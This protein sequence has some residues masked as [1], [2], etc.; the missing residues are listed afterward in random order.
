MDG[1]DNFINYCDKMMIATEGV[2]EGFQ[3]MK[4][5]IIAQLNKILNGAEK[6]LRSATFK[7]VDVAN[8]K[9]ENM[10]KNRKRESE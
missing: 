9:L 3:K 6:L 4:A 10:V 2:K 1:I 8:K 5:W 7:I